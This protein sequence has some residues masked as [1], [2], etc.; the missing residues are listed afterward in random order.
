MIDETFVQSIVRGVVERLDTARRTLSAGASHLEPAT[1][2]VVPESLN[3]LYQKYR[4][5]YLG[6]SPFDEKFST[7]FDTSLP[8]ELGRPLFCIYEEHLP[9]DSC[10][11]CQVRGF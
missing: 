10:G 1:N 6:A 5:Q 11:R 3:R 9:C 8:V 4:E 7:E 2:S